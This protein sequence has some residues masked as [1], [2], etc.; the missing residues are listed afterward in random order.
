MFGD[1]PGECAEDSALYSIRISSFDICLPV[2][3]LAKAGA[4]PRIS[5]RKPRE[6]SAHFYAASSFA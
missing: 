3:G 6:E 5:Q 1:L 4:S 2:V